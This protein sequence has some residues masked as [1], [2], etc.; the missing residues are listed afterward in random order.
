MG[1]S[2]RYTFYDAQGAVKEAMEDLPLLN[3]TSPRMLHITAKHLYN[4]CKDY[5]EEY[6]SRTT[7][8]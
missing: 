1:Q 8:G 7:H 4:A 3:E 6:E 2:N 5:I